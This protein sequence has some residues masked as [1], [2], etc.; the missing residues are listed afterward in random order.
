MAWLHGPA[1]NCARAYRRPVH[2]LG[3]EVTKAGTVRVNLDLG[4]R[5]VWLTLTPGEACSLG[6]ELVSRG[7]AA[8]ELEGNS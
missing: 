2:G 7:W 3:A 5:R 6:D 4:G 1:K 8:N